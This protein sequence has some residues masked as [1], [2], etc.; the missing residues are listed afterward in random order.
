MVPAVAQGL[1]GGVGLVEVP[2]HDQLARDAHLA[3]L[4]ADVDARLRKADA[5]GLAGE[6]DVREHRARTG[7]R[8]P[9]EDARD[10]VR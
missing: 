2:V 4:E 10:R 5:P 7:L 6:V 3:V 1:G 9:V 8:R